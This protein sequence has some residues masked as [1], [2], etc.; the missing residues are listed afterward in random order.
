MSAS[1]PSVPID[2]DLTRS[3]SGVWLV[4]MPKYLSQILNEYGDDASNGEIG[5][6]VRRPTPTSKAATS[7]AAA[8]R[9]M[10]VFFCILKNIRLTYL[11]NI[12]SSKHFS[13]ILVIVLY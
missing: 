8:G 7:G 12:L 6:I 5:R 10:D 9:A 11:E 13:L 3:T 2:V 1:D 4:K